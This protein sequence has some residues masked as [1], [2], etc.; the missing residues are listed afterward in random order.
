M[1]KKKNS[2]TSKNKQPPTTKPWL[3]CGEVGTYAKLNNKRAK[4][5][6]ERDHVPSA[7]AMLKAAK[8]HKKGMSP[9]KLAC[10]KRRLKDQALTIAIPKGLHRG[11]SRTCGSRNTKTQIKTDSEGLNSASN[12]DLAKIQKKLDGPPQHACADAYREAAKEVRAQDHEA[13]I[14]KV[15]AECPG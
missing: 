14:K 10:V 6:F 13:L 8:K 15:V 3:K 4:P 7:A 11:T 12:K 1:A 5:K 9:D 2:L